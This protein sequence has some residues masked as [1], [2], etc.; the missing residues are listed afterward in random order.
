[1][2]Y[3]IY[4][5]KMRDLSTPHNLQPNSLTIKVTNTLHQYQSDKLPPAGFNANVTCKPFGI[6]QLFPSLNDYM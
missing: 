6:K 3:L 5:W 2:F 4:N 1:M